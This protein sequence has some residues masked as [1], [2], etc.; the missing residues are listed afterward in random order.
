MPHSKCHMRS[1]SHHGGSTKVRLK[2]SLPS[3]FSLGLDQTDY[4]FSDG[5]RLERFHQLVSIWPYCMTTLYCKEQA[6]LGGLQCKT[7]IEIHIWL[8]NYSVQKLLTESSVL[9]SLWNLHPC[10]CVKSLHTWLSHWIMFLLSLS[11]NG[12]GMSNVNLQVQ[13]I[14]SFIDPQGQQYLSKYV[15]LWSFSSLF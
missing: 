12:Q 2:K 3:Q 13:F 8:A 15:L 6:Y 7:Q 10:L 4:S 1:G 11:E 14:W 5:F 9:H